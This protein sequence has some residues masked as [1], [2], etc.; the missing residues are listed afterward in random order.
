M[1]VTATVVRCARPVCDDF[2]ALSVVLYRNQ[3]KG[4]KILA[5]SLGGNAKT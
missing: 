4:V 5:E 2:A 1:A 3:E